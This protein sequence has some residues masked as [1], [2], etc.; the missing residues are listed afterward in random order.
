[1]V[2]VA[3]RSSQELWMNCPEFTLKVRSV[4]IK[5]RTNQP[6]TVATTTTTTTTTAT[7]TIITT[8]TITTTTKTTTTT[9]NNQQQQQQQQQ[10]QLKPKK[11]Y[12]KFVCK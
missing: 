3:E 1:L 2:K 4:Y 7:T 6:A 8:T 11:T 10:Q 12:L 5:Q 9:T